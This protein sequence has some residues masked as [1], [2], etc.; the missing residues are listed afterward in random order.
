MKKK[1]SLVLIA[2][3]CLG[4]LTACN[5]GFYCNYCGAD[6]LISGEGNR[7]LIGSVDIDLCDKHKSE[8]L[9]GTE[10]ISIDD[11]LGRL[12]TNKAVKVR[13]VGGDTDI[14]K[15]EGGYKVGNKIIDSR[16]ELKEFLKNYYYGNSG[17]ILSVTE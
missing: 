9:E 7:M 10:S 2:L 11:L 1:L 16:E 15:T 8:F 13:T 12:D 3:L 5:Q 17:K 14:I 6:K 4:V